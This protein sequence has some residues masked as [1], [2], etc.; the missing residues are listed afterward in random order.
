MLS[1]YGETDVTENQLSG[2]FYVAT[3]LR[4]WGSLTYRIFPHFPS[5][6]CKWVVGLAFS[7]QDLT[8]E[9]SIFVKI[10]FNFKKKNVSLN[11]GK[12][13]KKKF[14]P[15]SNNLNWLHHVTLKNLFSPKPAWQSVKSSPFEKF[16][17]IVSLPI[18]CQYFRFFFFIFLRKSSKPGH[19]HLV[20]NEFNCSSWNFKVEL[21]LW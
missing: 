18:L 16:K 1:L 12:P 9:I 21:Q 13:S 3:F 14:L 7:R 15:K 4:N 2:I 8:H 11:K 10:I 6:W 19:G 20:M 17:V 5:S